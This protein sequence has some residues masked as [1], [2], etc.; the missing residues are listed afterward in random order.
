MVLVLEIGLSS[1]ST[2]GAEYEYEKPSISR[3]HLSGFSIYATS[4]LTR[5]IGVETLPRDK[6]M[7][8]VVFGGKGLD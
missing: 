4:K 6:P 7:K 8:S 1:T 2:A 5:R 3:V